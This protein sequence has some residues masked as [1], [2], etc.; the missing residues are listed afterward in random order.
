[1]TLRDCRDLAVSTANPTSLAAYE[2]AV[3]QMHSYF[4]DPVAT[5]DAAL[6]RDPEFVMGHALRAGVLTTAAD[7][8][9]EPM[10]RQSI[11]AGEALWSKANERERGHL[12]AARAWLEG[13]F[14]RAAHRYAGI[15][16]DFPRDSL[17]LQIAHLGAFYLGQSTCLR[18]FVSRVL[19]YWDE[20]VPGYNYVLGM[21]AFGLEEMGDYERAE[22]TGR[23]ALELQPRDPWAV[24]AVAHVMEMQGRAAEGVAWLSEREANWA[25]DNGFAFHN[26][27]HLG[28]FHLDL[29]HT[30]RVLALYDEHIRRPDSKLPLEMVDAAAMLW[31]LHLRGVDVGHRWQELAEGW[32]TVSDQAY[33]AFNDVHAMM[34]FIGDGKLDAAQKLIGTLE[35]AVT[36]V[37][38]N[39]MMTR[40]VGLPM[41]RALLA[42]AQGRYGETVDLLLPIRPIAHRFGGSHAQRDIIALTLVEAALRG[43]QVRLARALVA[44]RID[45]KPRSPANWAMAARAMELLGDRTNAEQ[46]RARATR[47]AA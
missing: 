8:S 23:R 36:G 37:H 43:R 34:A 7:R 25:P 6:E 22:A 40:E 46:A 27:W 47:L 26:W 44:E 16:A 41:A 10:L 35:R 18:D 39:A 4:G 12:T 28:L 13:D 42:F 29:G 3:E 9:A 14:E 1:M 45:L 30:D 38:T 17:A 24:H 11:E 20:S 19:P 21:R 15:L 33:Y 31:R 32:A 5:I 2:S